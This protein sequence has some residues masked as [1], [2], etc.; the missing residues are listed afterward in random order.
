MP[1]SRPR[2]SRGSPAPAEL[3]YPGSVPRLPPPLRRLLPP[4][5]AALLALAVA[6]PVTWFVATRQASGTD[7]APVLT[8]PHDRAELRAELL[9][10]LPGR[11]VDGAVLLEV[12]S[13]IESA[14]GFPPGRYRVHLICGVL[15]RQ[16]DAPKEI[17]FSL[18]GGE[19]S[20][21]VVLPCPSTPL[22][23]EDELDT[24]GQPAG[25]IAVRPEYIEARPTSFQLLLQLVPVA[26]S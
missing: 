21:R 13:D 3:A 20:W 24:T 9:A 15:R 17:P 5:L 23:L 18:I 4:A 14:V 12:Y 8:G 19:Q 11:D 16:G 22:T 26:G 1:S 6:V 2:L 25:A 7:P 10:Q